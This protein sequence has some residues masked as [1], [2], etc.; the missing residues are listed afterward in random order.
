V[1]GLEGVAGPFTAAIGGAGLA[2]AP[3]WPSDTN[4][5]VVS[6]LAVDAGVMTAL[7]GDGRRL[8]VCTENLNPDVVMV[9]PAE[10]R[11]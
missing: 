11:V 7:V 3:R 4:K 8:L 6:A 2:S 5:L 1:T 9:K 10:D